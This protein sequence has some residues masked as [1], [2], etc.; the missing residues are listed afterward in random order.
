MKTQLTQDG[1]N[2]LQEELKILIEVK[3]PTTVER[4][5]KARAMGDL[6]ENSEYTAAKEELA[7]VEGR[8]KEIEEILKN[9]EVVENQT[10]GLEISLGS[11][12]TVE[13]NGEKDMFTIV[14]EFEADPMAKK[15]SSTSP[16]GK[17]LIGKK[18]NDTVIV[19]VP[20]GKITY[21]V[22]SIK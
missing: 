14:G 1:L 12:I 4:L 16:I 11:Q 5:S 13:A 22:L 17:A 10:N 6:S 15:L 2:K 9:A 18:M 19:E 3:R 8:V 21:K 7:F 20:S